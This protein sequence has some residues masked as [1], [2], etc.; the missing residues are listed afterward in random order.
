M[1]K[2]GEITGKT[3]VLY[4][5]LG[6]ITGKTRVLP[7]GINHHMPFHT[8]SG[9]VKP[10]LNHGHHLSGVTQN[11]PE[12]SHRNHT[13]Q[14]KSSGCH[15]KTKGW[16]YYSKKKKG[17]AYHSKKKGWAYHFFVITTNKDLGTK[18]KKKNI[19][20]FS[21]ITTHFVGLLMISIFHFTALDAPENEDSSRK[22]DSKTDITIT[23][24]KITIMCWSSFL[25]QK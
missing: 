22:S 24:G 2:L 15:T 9:H 21:P 13:N 18:L 11:D 5:E 6:E 23:R 3:R 1:A 19:L 10:H 12:S 17:W 8:E 20:L 16:A 4:S 25:S 7:G 14:K